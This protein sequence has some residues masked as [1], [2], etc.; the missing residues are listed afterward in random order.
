MKPANE[1]APEALS[2]RLRFDKPTCD[3]LKVHAVLHC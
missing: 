3:K 1:A 2:G